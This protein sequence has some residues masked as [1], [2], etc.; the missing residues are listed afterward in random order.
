MVH[1]VRLLTQAERREINGIVTRERECRAERGGDESASGPGAS[2]RSRADECTG[3][4]DVLP[5]GSARF[6]ED[7]KTAVLSR[8]P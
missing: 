1:G 2:A 6:V 3:A 4:M 7:E 8:T 5:H